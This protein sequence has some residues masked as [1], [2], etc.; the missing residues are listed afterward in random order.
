[1]LCKELP[2]WQI[3]VFLFWI[4][5]EIFAF[6]NIFDPDWLSPWMQNPWI[7]RADYMSNRSPRTIP[8]YTEQH[9][10]VFLKKRVVITFT[11]KATRITHLILT[12]YNVMLENHIFSLH[13]EQ[14]LFSRNS[15]ITSA[16]KLR[17]YMHFRYLMKCP[18]KDGIL[19]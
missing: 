2:L 10:I 9:L 19:F 4:L 16:Q 15:T 3:P 8:Q 5:L 6:S 18:H 1:M 7:Q 14:N 12:R 17:R 13:F 11:I